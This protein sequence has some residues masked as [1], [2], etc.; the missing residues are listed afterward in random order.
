MIK[1]IDIGNRI[2]KIYQINIPMKK[3]TE[4]EETKFRKK[5]GM[6]KLFKIF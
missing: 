2:H 4:K 3:L 1:I 6:R 5:R